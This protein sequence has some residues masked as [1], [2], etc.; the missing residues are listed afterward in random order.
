MTAKG[1]C[2]DVEGFFQAILTSGRLSSL[3]YGAQVQPGWMGSGDNSQNKGVEVIAT[4]VPE[5]VIGVQTDVTISRSDR[6]DYNDRLLGSVA[7]KIMFDQRQH[8]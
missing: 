1:T 6:L 5:G 8:G 7:V 2:F 4:E 3:G